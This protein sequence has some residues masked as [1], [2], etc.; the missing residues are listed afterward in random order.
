MYLEHVVEELFSHH[1]VAVEFLKGDEAAGCISALSDTFSTV[2]VH[3]RIL[4]KL[5]GK[6]VFAK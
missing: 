3:K 2:S 5:A 1:E 4:K 6:K